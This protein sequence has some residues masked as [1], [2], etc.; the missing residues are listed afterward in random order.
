MNLQDFLNTH[1]VDE[2]TDEVAISPRFVDSNG[3][4]LLFKIKA[5]TGQEF[6]EIRKACTTL[7]KGRKVEFDSQRFNL[8]VIINHTAEP[9][10]KDAASIKQVG[11]TTPEEYVQRV[12]LAGEIA[13]LAQKI[14]E[15]SG[16][17][18]D[19]SDLVEE[20]KN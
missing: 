15:L 4:P 1:L 20:A 10:F 9:N 16:F 11:V 5:M 17:D 19:M 14:S 12:L 6:D 2:L 3:K 7:K 13:T 8:K 18:V